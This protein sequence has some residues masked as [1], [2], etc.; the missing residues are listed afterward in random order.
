MLTP[1]VTL[2][3]AETVTGAVDMILP[4]G[5]LAAA[6]A[7]AMI[8][9]AAASVAL[10]EAICWL[11]AA[12]V[13]ATTC[14]TRNLPAAQ[15]LALGVHTRPEKARPPTEQVRL[16]WTSSSSWKALS[17]TRRGQ[18]QHSDYRLWLR[19]CQSVRNRNDQTSSIR[20]PRFSETSEVCRNDQP[21]YSTSEVFRNLGGLPRTIDP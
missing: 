10:A 6:V 5:E 2:I 13:R 16:S 17:K 15:A 12:S 7:S 14:S 1:P 19:D 21:A 11:A 3:E 9:A 4:P 18:E 8:C 20:P